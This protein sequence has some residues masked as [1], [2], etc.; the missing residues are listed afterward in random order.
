MIQKL[1]S[2]IAECK[3]VLM[4]TKKPDKVEYNTTVKVAGLGILVIGAL[5]FLLFLLK[6]IIF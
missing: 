5:G 4:I 6:E 2:F 3:R 1:K